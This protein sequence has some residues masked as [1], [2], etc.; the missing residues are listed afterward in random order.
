MIVDFLYRYILQ[1]VTIG[2]LLCFGAVIYSDH[3]RHKDFFEICQK[4]Y[5]KVDC[6]I[7]WRTRKTSTPVVVP[8]IVR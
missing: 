3:K 5:D 8:V 1:I 7:M 2:V 6:E 4:K